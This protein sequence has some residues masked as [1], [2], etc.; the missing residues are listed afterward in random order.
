MEE[1]VEAATNSSDAFGSY[2]DIIEN[3]IEYAIEAER[4]EEENEYGW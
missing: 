1:A 4:E 2:D 3:A